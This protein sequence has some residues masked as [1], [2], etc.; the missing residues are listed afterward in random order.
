[1]ESGASGSDIAD[2]RPG[3]RTKDRAMPLWAVYPE[4]YKPY[5]LMQWKGG[6]D[7]DA[8]ILLDSHIN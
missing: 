3:P 5:L 8:K 1:M 7:R 2:S 6:D 4:G